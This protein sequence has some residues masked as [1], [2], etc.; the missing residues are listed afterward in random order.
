MDSFIRDIGNGLSQCHQTFQTVCQNFPM[1]PISVLKT[2]ICSP[3]FIENIVKATGPL[4]VVSRSSNA[5]IPVTLTLS[6]IQILLAENKM[7][8]F[9]NEVCSLTLG[10]AGAAIGSVIGAPAG[11]PGMIIGAG[12]G[13]V[14]G[15]LL[16]DWVYGEVKEWLFTEGEDGVRPIDRIAEKFRA[17]T[18][19]LKVV[20]EVIAMIMH[21]QAESFAALLEHWRGVGGLGSGPGSRGIQ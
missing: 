3:I 5:L 9:A 17:A 18:D 6:T 19:T 4:K 7:D 20:A 12:V 21:G 10:V 1:D 2:T 15:G 14:S 16:G 8:K 13:G 11:P